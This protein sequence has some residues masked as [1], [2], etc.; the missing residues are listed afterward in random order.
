M[1][2]NFVPIQPETLAD[3]EIPNDTKNSAKNETSFCMILVQIK[4]ELK[5]S[6]LKNPL[7]C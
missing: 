6:E 2:I 3:L 5:F 1:K 7:K 4:E